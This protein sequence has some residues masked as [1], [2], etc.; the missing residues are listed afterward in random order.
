M[1]A[2]HQTGVQ[3]LNCIGCNKEYEAMNQSISMCSALEQNTGVLPTRFVTQDQTA[4]LMQ[5]LD[6]AIDQL[7]Q[8]GG[9]KGKPK[10]NPQ[11]TCQCITCCSPCP[12]IK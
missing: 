4:A 12:P 7:D 11:P 6:L 10:P 8:V 2:P 9:G 1:Q 3:S 5:I